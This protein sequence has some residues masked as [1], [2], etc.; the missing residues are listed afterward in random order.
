MESEPEVDIK[1]LQAFITLVD[2]KHVCASCKAELTKWEEEQKP[3]LSK[4]QK[5]L[6]H[7]MQEEF[8]TLSKSKLIIQSEI[9]RLNKQLDLI[10]ETYGPLLNLDVSIEKLKKTEAYQL[11]QN[12]QAEI[13]Y[14]KLKEKYEPLE[15]IGDMNV[16]IK[17]L[18]QEREYLKDSVKQLRSF[19]QEISRNLNNLAHHREKYLYAMFEENIQEPF[20][21][22]EILSFSTR[23]DYHSFKDILIRALPNI[24]KSAHI[25]AIYILP[26][27]DKL[28]C[29]NYDCQYKHK[30]KDVMIELLC[31]IGQSAKKFTKLYCQY[32][33][34]GYLT[35]YFRDV[36]IKP[37]NIKI[38]G[39]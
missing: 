9:N 1:S 29:Q 17:Q 6:E 8:R 19:K 20:F 3:F 18:T 10:A 39:T 15:M 37:F 33:I 31:G 4:L 21:K 36:I 23:R 16:K 32:C 2:G 26:K 35:I 13:Y 28:V 11:E 34:I 24:I 14:H 22:R 12:K 5:Q 30:H 7:Q 27:T 25:I 38:R